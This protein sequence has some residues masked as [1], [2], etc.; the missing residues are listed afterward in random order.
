MISISVPRKQIFSVSY[1]TNAG[2]VNSSNQEIEKPDQIGN[3]FQKVKCFRKKALHLID[4]YTVV[5]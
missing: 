4:I 1:Q 5:S 2:S 3:S